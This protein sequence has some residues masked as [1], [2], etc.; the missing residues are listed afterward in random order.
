MSHNGILA[1]SSD[2]A[3]SDMERKAVEKFIARIVEARKEKATCEVVMEVRLKA[4]VISQVYAGRK[5]AFMN[6]REAR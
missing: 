5:E 3:L 4:G 6:T 1:T 2:V